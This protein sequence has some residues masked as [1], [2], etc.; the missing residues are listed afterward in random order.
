MESKRIIQVEGLILTHSKHNERKQYM[1]ICFF[2]FLVNMTPQPI[3]GGSLTNPANH[4]FFSFRDPGEKLS[5]L[6]PLWILLCFSI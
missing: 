1:F 6:N 3:I 4:Y 5:E 2:S